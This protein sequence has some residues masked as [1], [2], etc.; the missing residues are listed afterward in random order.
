[1]RYDCVAMLLLAASASGAGA[2]AETTQSALFAPGLIFQLQ[3]SRCLYDLFGAAR[4][5]TSGYDGFSI[6]AFGDAFLAHVSYKDIP[7]G[8]RRI[9]RPRIGGFCPSS[10]HNLYWIPAQWAQNVI[11]R[12]GII[13]YVDSIS[14]API[15]IAALQLDGFPCVHKAASLPNALRKKGQLA[16]KAGLYYHSGISIDK[17]LPEPQS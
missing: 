7:L 16:G 15:L 6:V 14:A 4:T 11:T 3:S 9:A 10:Y 12:V 17:N 8:Q 13:S 5:S 2:R 1:M